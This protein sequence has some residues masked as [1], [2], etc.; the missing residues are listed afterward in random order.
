MDRSGVHRLLWAGGFVVLAAA[1]AFLPI[2]WGHPPWDQ[3]I[4]ND[5]YLQLETL[6]NRVTRLQLEESLGVLDP[7][8]LLAP[9]LDVHD[10]V[11]EVR[12]EK[13]AEPVVGVPLASSPVALP[14][15]EAFSNIRILVDPGHFGGAWSEVESRHQRLDEREPVR[16]GDLNW[17]TSRLLAEKL[18]SAGAE[19]LL[20]R[21]SPPVEP[22]PYQLSM[23]FDEEREA[24]YVL[25]E[26]IGE[27]PWASYRRLYP[28]LVGRLLLLRARRDII[29]EDGS[30]KMYNRF[31]LR[32]RSD[33]AVHEK[34]D[35]TV[36]IH[37]NT[38]GPRRDNWVMAFV[39]GNV[40]AGEA[41]TPAQRFWTIRRAVDGHFAEAVDLARSI[42]VAM[43][44]RLRIKSLDPKVLENVEV[45]KKIAIDGEHGVFGRNLAVVRRTSGLVV[46][47]EGP[48]VDN[49]AEYER[50]QDNSVWVDG[51]AYPSRTR[52]Y[53][54]AVYEGL[55]SWLDARR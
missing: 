33:M 35:L 12:L 40:M 19:V 52:E 44:R 38:T 4:T 54:D 27:E 32:R 21:G 41:E 50:L 42:M 47:I 13:D 28:S 36:S 25:G 9:Y 7:Q 51:R 53:S 10:E 6:G 15:P 29:A 55:K 30:F 45:P 8:G 11:L 26:R 49:K 1:V 48:C 22:F 20:T 16:E 37:Y 34:V 39:A 3:E 14:R 17:A 18:E 2:P 31:D 23:D 5:A 46:L 24:A 43:K